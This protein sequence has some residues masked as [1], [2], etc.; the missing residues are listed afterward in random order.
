[1]RL[2][3]DLSC[4]NALLKLGDAGFL[5]QPE[6]RDSFSRMQ[7]ISSNLLGQLSNDCLFRA[8]NSRSH[9]C[10]HFEF[11]SHLFLNIPC[12]RPQ[13]SMGITAMSQKIQTIPTAK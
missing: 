13:A 3:R 5:R 2:Y 6:L 8:L 12:T 7:P 1:M 9:I 4:H 11:L 10:Q